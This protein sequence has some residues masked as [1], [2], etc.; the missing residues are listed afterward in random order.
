MG[1]RTQPLPRVTSISGDSPTFDVGRKEEQT[2]SQHDAY[3]LGYTHDT[4][5]RNNGTPIGNEEQIP[6]NRFSV[7][8][9]VCNPTS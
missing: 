8:I 9:E 2:S 5:N 1:Q 4:M 6:S 3:A 7:G